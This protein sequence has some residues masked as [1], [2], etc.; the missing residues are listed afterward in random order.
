[1]PEVRV[2]HTS[3]MRLH[4]NQYAAEVRKFTNEDRSAVDEADK[5]PPSTYYMSTD[6]WVDLGSPDVITITVRSGDELNV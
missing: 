5:L 3:V 1:M 4:E 2:I 6:A